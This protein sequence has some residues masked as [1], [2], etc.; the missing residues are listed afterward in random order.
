MM[1]KRWVRGLAGAVLGSALALGGGW[2]TDRPAAALPPSLKTFP[3]E[4]LIENLTAYIKEHPQEPNGYYRLAR[5]HAAAFVDRRQQM[6]DWGEFRAQFG[7]VGK[8]NLKGDLPAEIAETHLVPALTNFAEAIKLDPKNATYHLGAAYLMEI[9]AP[10]SNCA[11][12]GAPAVLSDTD[13]T[14]WTAL[15]QRL[16]APVE[17]DR[18][19][20]LK[21]LRTDGIGIASL[22]VAHLKDVAPAIRTGAQ[23]LLTEL[24]LEQAIVEYRRAFELSI[25]R[26]NSV[27]TSSLYALVSYEAGKSFLRLVNQRGVRDEEKKIVETFQAKL[28]AMEE[29]A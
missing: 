27:T 20:A 13:T 11:P 4:R 16:D 1:A 8:I 14:K 19:A 3:V 5:V 18:A 6:E 9:A 22:L 26:D 2:I 17:A 10:I 23:S 15:I 25:E 7:R 21:E 24:W 28:T 29:A 12:L